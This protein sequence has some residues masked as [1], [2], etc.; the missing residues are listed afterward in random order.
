MSSSIRAQYRCKS[1]RSPRASRSF[2]PLQIEGPVA[3]FSDLFHDDF[4]HLAL[5][6][7]LLGVGI[8]DR[9]SEN[10]LQLVDHL[11]ENRQ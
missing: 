8:N 10:L 4:R 2:D 9:L 11:P 6:H 7:H 5:A 3:R 1:V